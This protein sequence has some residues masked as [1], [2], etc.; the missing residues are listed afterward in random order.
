MN[1]VIS[2]ET[3]LKMRLAKL[4]KKQTKEHIEKCRLSRIGHTVS[5]ETREKIRIGNLGKKY[6]FK[7]RPK[8][9]GRIVWNKG[10]IGTIS[11]EHKKKLREALKGHIP[12]NK[13]N[14]SEKRICPI[15][16]NKKSPCA[17]VCKKCYIHPKKINSNRKKGED[18]PLWKG[19]LER[20]LWHNNL[21]R[22]VKLGN[23]GSHTFEEWEKL[24]KKYNRTCPC[25]GRK[26][27]EITLSR[28]HIIPLSKGGSDN[29][30]NIQ[31]LCRSCNCK[32]YNKIINYEIKETCIIS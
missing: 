16:N 22:V 7:E 30:E 21:R 17:I 18:S 19:G 28:D 25:C 10:K 14:G 31:P 12:W 32:K 15:C 27:P 11:D 29:I 3:R 1:K 9:K 5:S 26:E 23:G 4:G 20:K 8:A 13:G 24:K 2:E 6:P